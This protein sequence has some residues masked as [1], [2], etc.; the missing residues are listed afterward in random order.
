MQVWDAIRSF[1][2]TALCTRE[3]EPIARFC[4]SKP[5]NNAGKKDLHQVQKTP[6]SVPVRSKPLGACGWA[7][8][9]TREHGDD[10]SIQRVR[11]T[12]AQSPVGRQLHQRSSRRFGTP[13]HSSEEKSAADVE[14]ACFGGYY[15]K[16]AP[17]VPVAI[18]AL[19]TF[20]TKKTKQNLLWRTWNCVERTGSE[21]GAQ[22]LLGKRRLVRQCRAH[23]HHRA[24]NHTEDQ[25]VIHKKKPLCACYWRAITSGCFDLMSTNS[26]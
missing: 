10:E 21:L 17:Q 13:P 15:H 7:C 11:G 9:A 12:L 16:S 22:H 20:S 25:D 6:T 2:Q 5:C 18:V 8:A 23:S 4:V 14:N 19:E 3:I 26:D 24:T 1:L